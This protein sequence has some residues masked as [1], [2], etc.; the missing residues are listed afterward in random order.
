MPKVTE[1]IYNRTRIPIITGGL[2]RDKEDVIESLRAG[3]VAISTSNEG[4]WYM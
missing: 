2:I 4:V 1:E 3:A